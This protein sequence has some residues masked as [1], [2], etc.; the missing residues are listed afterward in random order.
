[1]FYGWGKKEREKTG[2]EVTREEIQGR[3]VKQWWLSWENH[4]KISFLYV[5]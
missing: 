3:A 1:M 5:I 2:I 4:Q